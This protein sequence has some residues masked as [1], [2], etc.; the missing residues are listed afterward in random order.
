MAT[1]KLIQRAVSSYI[2]NALYTVNAN[3][4]KIRLPNAVGV[5]NC[6]ILCLNSANNASVSSI[7]DDNTNSWPGTATITL[8]NH[9]CFT[10]LFVL[11]NAH[12]G[13]TTITIN[14]S[15]T[16]QLFRCEIY[17]FNNIATTTPVNGT[18]SATSL[19][20][21]AGASA[22]TFTPGNNN[23]N[24]GN[25]LFHY[26]ANAWGGSGGLG[27]ASLTPG[28]GWTLV[29]SDVNGS[30]ETAFAQYMV[31][32]TSASITP[33]VTVP[34]DSGN[35][36]H[37]SVAVALA[38]AA[39]SAGTGTPTG[40]HVDGVNA[41]FGFQTASTSK[42][43]LFPTTGNLRV[44]V[45]S[46]SQRPDS[47]TDSESQTWTRVASVANSCDAWYCQNR[48]AV[49]N[50]LVTLN[51]SAGF[52]ANPTGWTFFDISGADPSA[53]DTWGAN[54]SGAITATPTNFPSITPGVTTGVTVQVSGA[55]TPGTSISSP[56][57][58][59]SDQINFTGQT[60][61]IMGMTETG[62]IG[63]YYFSSTAAQ[64]WSPVY[65]GAG[66]ANSVAVSFKAAPV[67]G[68]TG[69]DTAS[70]LTGPV[71]AVTLQ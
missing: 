70:I 33:T 67:S 35:N 51:R 21:S 9:N 3:T 63:H 41:F 45:Y 8:S 65:S 50:L 14:L 42:T 19:L 43:F 24:G 28:S 11:P 71:V 5:G 13:V 40:I 18:S 2:T 49:N 36:E 23:A 37:N 62:S 32:A 69:A 55:N 64:N 60:N 12:A 61:L 26:S 29:Q 56:S 10:S 27:V 34:S 16:V 7:A 20:S 47:I 44:L 31:Q 38:L 66:T 57:G 58:V 4:F 15:T 48:S 53:Y 1:P 54:A 6:L 52:N 17:E 68:P 30:F 25:L 46:H 59:I 22:G 39:G